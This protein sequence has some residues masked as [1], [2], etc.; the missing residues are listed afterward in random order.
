M[1]TDQPEETKK[2]EPPACPSCGKTLVRSQIAIHPSALYAWM[3]DCDTQ[4]GGIQAEI[5]KARA[6]GLNLK[7][8]LT[9]Q[10]AP[11]NQPTRK[12]HPVSRQS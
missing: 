12:R 9:P 1:Q 5:F 7:I 6:A 11:T 4:A 8:E 2:P 3:C 10:N